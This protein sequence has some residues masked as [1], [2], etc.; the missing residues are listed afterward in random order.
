MKSGARTHAGRRP[1]ARRDQAQRRLVQEESERKG[2]GEARRG[3]AGRGGAGQGGGRTVE[4][5]RDGLR[6][7]RAAGSS[8]SAS[9]KSQFFSLSFGSGGCIGSAPRLGFWR[10][11][12][13]APVYF[14][15]A[16][17]PSRATC[18]RGPEALCC[19]SSC[20]RTVSSTRGAAVRRCPEGD[21]WVLATALI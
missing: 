14:R 7:A 19:G 1:R 8:I 13:W 9:P 6:V 20:V 15:W 12:A 18:R 5:A 11:G 10:G 17:T 2:R 3:E 21:L 4:H 16:G